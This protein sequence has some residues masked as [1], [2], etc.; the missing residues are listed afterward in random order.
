MSGILPPAEPRACAVVHAITSAMD[1][2]VDK[3]AAELP[4]RIGDLKRL[5]HNRPRAADGTTDLT[6]P[7]LVVSATDVEAPAAAAARCVA[8][9]PTARQAGS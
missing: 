5:A 3:R 8:R 4:Y 9:A 6:R 7:V 2:E 1:D